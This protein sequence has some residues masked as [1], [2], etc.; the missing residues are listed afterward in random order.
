MPRR[1]L[2]VLVAMA[3]MVAMMVVGAGAVYADVLVRHTKNAGDESAVTYGGG[4]P[5]G[6]RG[7]RDTLNLPEDGTATA[8]WSGGGGGPGGG[9]GGRCEAERSGSGGIVNTKA[10]GN[11]DCPY[12]D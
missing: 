1:R 12:T 3:V 8:T 5:D 4:G 2:T 6:G 10:T 7:G 11:R 9:S